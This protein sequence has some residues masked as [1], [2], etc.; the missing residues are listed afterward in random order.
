M[1]Q[2]DYLFKLSFYFWIGLHQIF[3]DTFSLVT[4]DME[5]DMV[6]VELIIHSIHTKSLVSYFIV[7]YLILQIYDTMKRL[8][9]YEMD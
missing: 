6:Y 9:S 4:V 3:V 2:H 8:M 5:V 7:S 1:H